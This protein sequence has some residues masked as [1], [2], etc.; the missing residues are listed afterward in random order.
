M[1]GR[2]SGRR[3]EQG[4]SR[5]DGGNGTE[6]GAKGGSQGTVGSP[7]APKRTPPGLRGL[8]NDKNRTCWLN[9]VLGLLLRIPHLICWVADAASHAAEA[10]SPDKTACTILWSLLTLAQQ[11]NT[12]SPG[13][14]A[15]S[16]IGFWTQVES[17]RHLCTVGPMSPTRNFL[18]VLNYEG[19]GD[20]RELLNTFLSFIPSLT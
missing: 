18:T 17:M 6:E 9:S 3:S 13:N 7:D 11:V 8:T 5:T 16:T 1:G 14:H 19:F 4:G 2:K 20:P 10:S 12:E 15:V